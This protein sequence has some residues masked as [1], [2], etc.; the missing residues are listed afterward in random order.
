MGRIVSSALEAIGGAAIG[1]VSSFIN[2]FFLYDQAK[3]INK[4]LDNKSES[5]H[6]VINRC[7]GI[8]GYFAGTAFIAGNIAENPRDPARYL[9]L[10]SNIVVGSAIKYFRHKKNE[11]KIGFHRRLVW[12]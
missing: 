8:V 10:V 2:P 1:F 5:M 12:F 4:A 9:P 7:V 6:S 3:A 11:E